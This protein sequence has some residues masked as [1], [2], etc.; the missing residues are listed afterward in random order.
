MV[1][2]FT[3]NKSIGFTICISIAIFSSFV[4]SANL[5]RQVKRLNHKVKKLRDEIRVLTRFLKI[6]PETSKLSAIKIGDYRIKSLID[7]TFDIVHERENF[8]VYRTGAFEDGGHHHSFYVNNDGTKYFMNP[9][10]RGIQYYSP[11]VPSLSPSS[12]PTNIPPTELNNK[13]SEYCTP[14]E[15]CARCTGDCDSDSDCL[16]NLRCAQRSGNTNVPGCT[17]DDSNAFTGVDFCKFNC[18]C[19][20]T[21]TFQ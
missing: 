7:G 6:D 17:Q 14:L 10:D 5:E 4:E 19:E 15:R 18:Y 8:L 20:S 9:Y 12:S 2:F 16:D 13:G 1:K 11:S 3:V 21:R